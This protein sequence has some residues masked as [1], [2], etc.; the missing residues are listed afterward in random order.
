MKVRKIIVS[1]FFLALVSVFISGC[2]EGCH[3]KVSVAVVM[4]VHSNANKIPLDSD[5]LNS[6]LYEASYSHGEVAFISCEGNPK[7]I[8]HQ[9]L[10]Q[11]LKACRRI[12]RG[13]LLKAILRN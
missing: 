8:Q 5:A 9:S 3:E 6:A 7:V 2:N 11:V 13:S 4:G 1:M 12:N 10:N